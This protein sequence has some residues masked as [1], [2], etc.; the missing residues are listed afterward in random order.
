MKV[1]STLLVVLSAMMATLQGA[2]AAPVDDT[3]P[4]YHLGGHT[5]LHEPLYRLLI[6]F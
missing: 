3:D 4:G 6:Y 1:P 5:S 2:V